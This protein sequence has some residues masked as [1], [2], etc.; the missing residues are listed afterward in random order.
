MTRRWISKWIME[1]SGSEPCLGVSNDFSGE[2]LVLGER[3]CEGQDDNDNISTSSSISN[4]SLISSNSSPYYPT[5]RR[6]LSLNLT[7]PQLKWHHKYLLIPSYTLI[8]VALLPFIQ[9]CMYTIGYRIGKRTLNYVLQ[10]I[11]WNKKG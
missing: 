7:Y 11:F 1:A 9:G 3:E 8:F 5:P 10:N 4:I 2:D 6:T